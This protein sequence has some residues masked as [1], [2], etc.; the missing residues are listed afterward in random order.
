MSI[1]VT[2]QSLAG[3]ALKGAA[4]DLGVSAPKVPKPGAAKGVPG[5][6]ESEDS[7]TITGAKQEAPGSGKEALP[8]EIMEPE[9]AEKAEERFEV[10]GQGEDEAPASEGEQM[11]EQRDKAELN[12]DP[13][14]QQE[15]KKAL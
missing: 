4:A 14:V 15:E 6:R 8:V 11:Q 2:G 9:K 10:K 1:S 5:D 12:L 3:K 13:D 7:R